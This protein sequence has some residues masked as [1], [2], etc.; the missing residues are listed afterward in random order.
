MERVPGL[1]RRAGRLAV[2][3]DLDLTVDGHAIAVRG[4]GDRVRVIVD[5]P[6][7]AWRLFQANRPGRHLVRSITDTLD[8][9]GIDVDVVVG[10]RTVATVGPSAE[11]GRLLDALGLD[12]VEVPNPLNDVL[13]SRQQTWLLVGLAFLG[14]AFLGTRR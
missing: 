7:T 1:Q 3:A 2:E 4:A 9:L 12:N 6:R 11:S 10:D 14:G 8:A 5:E 13:D